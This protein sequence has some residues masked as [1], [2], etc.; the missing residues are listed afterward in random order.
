[1]PGDEPDEPDGAEDLAPHIPSARSFAPP[2]VFQRFGEPDGRFPDARK[3]ELLKSAVRASIV[4][5]LLNRRGVSLSQ[6]CRERSLGWGTVQHHIHLLER[7][8]LI[9]SV[10][11]GRDRLYF[12]PSTDRNLS[13]M[14]AHLAN[15]LSDGLARAI[16]GSPGIS[17]N[18]LCEQLQITRKAFRHRMNEMV[19]AGLVW[20][21]RRERRR[22]YWPTD[23]LKGLLADRS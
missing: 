11:H 2:P 14:L 4:D 23:L 6:L 18:K 13:V 9:Y 22:L 5:L 15:R 21:E 10:A 20:E 19:R 8:G 1:M 3:R 7:A 17:Q 16:A 12:H